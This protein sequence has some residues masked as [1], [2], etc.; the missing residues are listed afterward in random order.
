MRNTSTDIR[1]S[2]FYYPY[3]FNHVPGFNFP[4]FLVKQAIEKLHTKCHFQ[5]IPSI[6]SQVILDLVIANSRNI[7]LI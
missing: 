1:F 3:L 7:I 6:C 4:E 2:W 5:E